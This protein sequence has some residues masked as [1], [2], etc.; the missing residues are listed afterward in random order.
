MSQA[1]DHMFIM[2]V[3]DD[4]LTN[5]ITT[6][7]LQSASKALKIVAFTSGA[8]ALDTL[9]ALAADQQRLPDLILLDINMPIMDGW[10]FLDK[11]EPLRLP[12]KLCMLTSSIS[13]LD[14]NRA[15]QYSCVAGFITKPL[16]AE[17]ARSL[18]SPA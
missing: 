2:L 9:T 11:F 12:I 1:H 13:Q 18:V 16:L 3:D 15:G 10:Q 6:Y 8:D 7:A 17:V 14:R 4:G 5:M